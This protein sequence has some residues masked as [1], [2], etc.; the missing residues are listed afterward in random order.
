[1]HR[2]E[3]NNA[4]DKTVVKSINPLSSQNLNKQPASEQTSEKH[5]NYGKKPA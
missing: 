4:K 3:D 2:H 1:M 5:K